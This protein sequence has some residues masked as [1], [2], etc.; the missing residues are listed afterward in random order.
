MGWQLMEMGLDEP[1]MTRVAYRAA[2][3]LYV[4]NQMRLLGQAC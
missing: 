3:H 4:D 1:G 2:E